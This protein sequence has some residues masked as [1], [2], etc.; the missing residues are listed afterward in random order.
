VT[1]HTAKPLIAA[2]QTRGSRGDSAGIPAQSLPIL[3]PDGDVSSRRRI[4]ILSAFHQL[5]ERI[6]T[7]EQFVPSSVQA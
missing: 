7:T 5:M 2:V 3:L 1:Q 4:G 6:P